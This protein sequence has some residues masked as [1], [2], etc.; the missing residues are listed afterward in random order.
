MNLPSVYNCTP[1][2][3][4]VLSGKIS[5]PRAPRRGE[6]LREWLVTTAAYA[7]FAEKLGV[8]YDAERDYGLSFPEADLIW[9][10]TLTTSTGTHRVV[11]NEDGTRVAFIEED[12]S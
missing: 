8:I 1:L 11:L 12:E 3:A 5:H 10:M 4:D 9:G 7:R 6:L 2:M